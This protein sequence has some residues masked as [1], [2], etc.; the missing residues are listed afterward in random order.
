MM[1]RKNN[2]IYKR[3]KDEWGWKLLIYVDFKEMIIRIKNKRTPL[4]LN[5]D[6]ML[7]SKPGHT[8]IK[9]VQRHYETW[10]DEEIDRALLGEE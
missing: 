9:T 8:V 3:H 4:H 10:L 1:I 6:G 7:C 5:D 2:I